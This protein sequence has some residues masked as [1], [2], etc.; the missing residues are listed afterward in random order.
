MRPRLPTQAAKISRR[1]E[2]HH[3][4]RVAARA[5]AG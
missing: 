1:A 3:P 4:G 2:H 5:G